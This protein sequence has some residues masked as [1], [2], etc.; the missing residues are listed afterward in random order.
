MLFLPRDMLRLEKAMEEYRTRYKTHLA[1]IGETA[2][3]SSETW[4]DNPAFDEAQMQARGAHTRY[5][6]LEAMRN[7]A[8]VITDPPD[9]S[10]VQIG[11][12]VRYKRD[13]M[14]RSDE[15]VIG[16]YHLVDSA[17]DEVSA[18]SPLGTL[19]LGKAAGETVKGKIA[20]K[21]VQI[22]IEHIEV[23]HE[24]FEDFVE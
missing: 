10:S 4:H 16:S 18:S 5:R 9:G 21:L 11:C 2:D 3:I 8:T 12:R 22:T 6:E 20:D 14:R 24:Y 19:L 1:S 17:D 23:A 15:V 13:D 7:L